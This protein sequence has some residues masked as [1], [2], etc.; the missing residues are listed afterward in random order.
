[1]S[2]ARDDINASLYEDIRPGL[3]I[4]IALPLRF[5]KY[6]M[7]VLEKIYHY[8]LKRIELY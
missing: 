6:N 4:P 1:M 8:L 2:L 5:A 3:C 7:Y